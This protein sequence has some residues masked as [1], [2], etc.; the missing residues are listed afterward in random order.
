MVTLAEQYAK[1]Q[2]EFADD[3]ES[4]ILISHHYIDSNQL[5]D[6]SNYKNF[7]LLKFSDQSLLQISKRA[8]KFYLLAIAPDEV[9][10]Y[11]KYQTEAGEITL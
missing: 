4:Q 8:N 6:I 1:T 7:Q 5:I 11:L 10:D 3:K 9:I 2:I